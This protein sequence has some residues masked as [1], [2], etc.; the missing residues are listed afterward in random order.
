[1]SAADAVKIARAG[2]VEVA[3]DEAL[4]RM[5]S[6]SRGAV[7]SSHP[8]DPKGDTPTPSRHPQWPEPALADATYLP[9]HKIRA[10][11]VA[12]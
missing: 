2:G 7:G 3:L 5:A 12:H 4:I 9:E 1:M 11:S 8:D 10:A 6:A